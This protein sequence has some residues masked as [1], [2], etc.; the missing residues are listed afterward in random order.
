MSIFNKCQL[1]VEYFMYKE[2]GMFPYFHPIDGNDGPEVMMN[3]K[4]VVM[5]GSNNYLCL[6][7]DPRVKEATI[8]AIERYGTSNTGSRFLNGSLTLHEELEA[9]L[10]QFLEKEAV[11]TYTTGFQSNQGVLV[12]LIGKD[13]VLILDKDCH[14]SIVQGLLILKG[15]NHRTEVRRYKH[16]D[17]Q[18]LERVL[19]K[20]PY[21]KGKLVV[22]DGVFS[23][24]GE[25]APLDEM[26]RLANE[27]N[28]QLLIDDAHGIGVIGP[29]GKGTSHHFGL[30]DSVDLITGTF[31]K[32]LASIGGFVA[33]DQQVI[34]YIQM[35]SP[36][37]MFSASM[38]APQAASALEAIKIIENEPWHLEKLRQNTQYLIDELNTLGFTLLKTETAIIPILIGD[39]HQT[40]VAWKT[41]MDHGVYVNPVL[42]PAVPNGSQLLR[43]SLM[44][45]HEQIHLEKM[46]EGFKKV[47]N[48]IY[49]ESVYKG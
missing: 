40:L 17:M 30:N 37:Y 18:D 9:K 6:S 22:T 28:A 27:Y 24:T 36:S 34:D 26:T 43:I 12:P 44:S 2:N 15:M 1:P 38:A 32:S 23:M 5:G 21:D 8:K 16:N 7:T 39:D 41:L 42:H 13:D 3:G 33:G 35:N 20:V 25:L 49:M 11:L 10:A 46:V 31:S 48:S 47:K 4:T 14:N 19:K 29:S 45:S